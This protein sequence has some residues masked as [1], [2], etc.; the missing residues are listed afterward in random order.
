MIDVLKQ[1]AEDVVRRARANGA[2]AADAFIQEDETFSVSVRM[3]EVETLKEA[4]SRA[5]RLRVFVG[6]RTATSQTSDLS[7]EVVDK[8]VDETVEMA[9]LTSEDQGGG[10]PDSSVFPSDTPDLQL[11]DPRWADVKPQER[12]EWARRAEEASLKADSSITN[13]EGGTF[14]YERSRRVL[15]NTLGFVG[16]YEGTVA[17]LAAVPIAGSNGNMQRDYW[18]SVARHRDKIE[19]PEQVGRRAAERAIRRLGARKVPTCQVPVVFDPVTARTLIGHVFSAVAGDAVYRRR[20]FLADQA[21]Q[22]VASSEVTIVDVARIA[23]GLGS[24]PFDDEGVGTQ[25]TPVVENGVL[26]NYLHSA[27]SA[28]KLNA[29]PTGNGSRTESGAVVVG[30]TNFY[31]NAG[32]YTPEE[33]VAS[34]RSGLYVVELMGSGVNSVNGDYSRGVAGL[35]IENGRFAYPVQEVTIAGNLRQMLKDIEMIGNDLTFMGSI[36]APS[37]KLRSMVVSGK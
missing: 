18:F 27:Y 21:G 23:G 4:V 7:P 29:R 16:G 28:R 2:T 24:S 9:R 31:L 10:L 3:G 32:P 36:A 19:S 8:L 33:I 37:I 26:R 25:T 30:P 15:A 11:D 5:L 17:S 1:T 34:I 13:S 14:E 22:A 35:W 6:K 20:S 12:I